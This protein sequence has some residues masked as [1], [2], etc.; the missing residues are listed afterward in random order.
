MKDVPRMYVGNVSYENVTCG[1]D[2]SNYSMNEVKMYKL[3]GESTCFLGVCIP[4]YYWFSF[5][6]LLTCIS[7]TFAILRFIDFGPVRI[8]QRSGWHNLAG[9][10]FAFISV[11]VSLYAKAQGLGNG[12][13]VMHMLYNISGVDDHGNELG[14]HLHSRKLHNL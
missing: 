4:Q 3:L 11:A 9:Y 5:S 6:Y 12:G 8:L 10:G 13:Y 7:C 1:E 2:N 14:E